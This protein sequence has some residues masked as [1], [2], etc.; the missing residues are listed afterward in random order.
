MGA[1]IKQTLERN[2]DVIMNPQEIRQLTFGGLKKLEGGGNREPEAVSARDIPSPFGDGTQV[3]FT[4]ELMPTE[5]IV[6]LKSKAP[7]NS[8]KNVQYSSYML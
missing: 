4:T 3:V 5:C 1:E 2:F 7:E 8:K 6:R